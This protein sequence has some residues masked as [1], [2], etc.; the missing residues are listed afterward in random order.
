M[1]STTNDKDG[2]GGGYYRF[3]YSSLPDELFRKDVPVEEW[4]KLCDKVGPEGFPPDSLNK[5]TPISK[6]VEI[7]RIAGIALYMWGNAFP[8]AYPLLLICA[9]VFNASAMWWW[10][11]KGVTLYTVVL[12]GLIRY[13]FKPNVFILV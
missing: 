9:F 6:D 8:F 1:T 7:E 4:L 3:N 12:F 10:I 5:V 13:Y 11:V 2:G